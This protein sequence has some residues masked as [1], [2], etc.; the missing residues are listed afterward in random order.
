MASVLKPI[1]LCFAEIVFFFD[2]YGAGLAFI[3]RPDDA[4]AFHS[5]QKAGGAAITDAE[6]ALQG[7]RG[8]LTDFDDE[9]DGFVVEVIELAVAFAGF[10][11]LFRRFEYAFIVGGVALFF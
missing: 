7:R 3:G 2:E 10:A 11:G 9:A 4:G 1:V 5:V 8:S 6:P